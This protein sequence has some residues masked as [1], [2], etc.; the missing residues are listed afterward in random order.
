MKKDGSQ[1]NN[2]A[3]F[4][5]LEPLLAGALLVVVALT[6]ITGIVAGQYGALAAADRTKALYLA[7]EGLEAL[8]NLRDLSAAELQ[9]GEW[10][11]SRVDGTWELGASP[12]VTESRFTR[13]LTIEGAGDEHNITV[14]VSWEGVHAEE[15]VVLQSRL[16]NW[17]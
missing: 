3:G 6:I 2:N 5:L 15:E 14:A 8:R 11:L 7:G 10:G 13:T 16:T 4:T 9:E 1:L 17:R 12:D